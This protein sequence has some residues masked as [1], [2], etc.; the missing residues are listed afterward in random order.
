MERLCQKGPRRN[1]SS[2]GSMLRKSPK[3]AADITREHH[4]KKASLSHKIILR[5]QLQGTMAAMSGRAVSPCSSIS[6]I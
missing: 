6:K 4:V 2:L 5:D 3:L 1:H